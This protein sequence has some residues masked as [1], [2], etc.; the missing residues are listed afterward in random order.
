[1]VR[2]TVII[3]IL[4]ISCS[5]ELDRG[6]TIDKMN[7]EVQ[8]FLPY[9][10]DNGVVWVQ[11]INEDNLRRVQI[12]KV[13][14]RGIPVVKNNITKNQLM[15]EFFLLL[16]MTPKFQSSSKMR[17]KKVIFWQPMILWLINMLTL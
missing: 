7:S 4:L 3:L 9:D 5:P 10:F 14:E 2:L 8:S 17:E 6:E 12:Y 1:M 16:L 11:S 15:K 13:S